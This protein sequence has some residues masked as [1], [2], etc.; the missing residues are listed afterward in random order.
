MPGSHVATTEDFTNVTGEVKFFTYKVIGF[1]A[2]T[3]CMASSCL[4]SQPGLIILSHVARPITA[5]FLQHKKQNH[6]GLL[7]RVHVPPTKT[8]PLLPETALN[9]WFQDLSPPPSPCLHSVS[10]CGRAGLDI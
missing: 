10:G 8:I 6:K 1:W 2:E 4:L 5:F 7:L 9:C 3:I